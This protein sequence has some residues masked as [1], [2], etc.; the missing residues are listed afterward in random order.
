MPGGNHHAN[1][2]DIN[3]PDLDLE[4]GPPEDQTQGRAHDDEHKG[5]KGQNQQHDHQQHQDNS[6][7]G[8]GPHQ[9]HGSKQGGS[10]TSL[11]GSNSGN[12]KVEKVSK[13]EQPR[14]SLFDGPPVKDLDPAADRIASHDTKPLTADHFY[15][16]M[17]LKQ[18]RSAEEFN[19]KLQKLAIHNGLYK[20]IWSELVWLQVSPD[21]EGTRGILK[22]TTATV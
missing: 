6:Q 22:L 3:L 7:E 4:K 8:D 5:H 18:P 10:H 9:Q 17:G 20:T 14:Q 13:K 1:Q 11:D 2:P 15:E 19:T 21:A 16:L 12:M